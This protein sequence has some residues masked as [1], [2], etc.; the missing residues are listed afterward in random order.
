MAPS[1]GNDPPLRRDPIRYRRVLAPFEV[2]RPVDDV[3][4][5]AAQ[6]VGGEPQAVDAGRRVG[7]VQQV[8]GEHPPQRLYVRMSDSSV[9]A[10]LDAAS[11][12]QPFL[13]VAPALDQGLCLLQHSPQT[14]VGRVSFTSESALKIAACCIA[15]IESKLGREEASRQLSVYLKQLRGEPQ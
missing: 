14:I 13:S 7:D 11:L 6:G 4:V 9:V 12:D 8:D 2:S 3:Q 15:H 10:P 5:E 1:A